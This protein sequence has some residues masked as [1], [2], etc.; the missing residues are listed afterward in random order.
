MKQL[1]SKMGWEIV[2]EEWPDFKGQIFKNRP[3]NVVEM[4]ENTVA[5]YPD[6]LGFIGGDWRLTF[7]E[8]DRIVNRVTAG[9]E[10]HGVK[11]GDHVA[12]LLGVQMEFPL[13]FFALM[14][15][16]AVVVPLNTRFKGMELAY[17][18]ND[19]ESQVLIVDEEYWPSIDSTRGQLKGIEKIF[20]NG[21]HVPR[22]T[23]PFS[24]LK[25][26]K[27]DTFSRA[28]FSESDDAAI[29]Y[30]SGTTGKPKGAILH[31]RGF[32][33]SAMLV[34]DFV[35]FEP[36]D[37][38]MCCIPLFHITGLACVM[39][40]TIFSGVT[41]VY[42]REFK[43]KDF[44]EI[45]AKEKVTQYMG[46]INVVWLMVN[47]PDF[48]QYDF[49]SFKAA[50]LGGSP[51]TE[52][53]VR[54]IFNKLPHLQISVGYG[55]TEHFAIATSTP[56]EDALRKIK[57]VGQC[58]PT[59]DVK[60]V[61][62]EGKEVETGA[63]GEIVLKS[64]KVFKG[65]W[66]NLKAT[67]ET[68]VDGWLHTGDIGKIDE[69][70]FIYILDRKKDMINRGGE[71]IYSLE[72]ENVLGDNPKVLE[73][74]VVGVPDAMMGEVVKACIVL[75][76]GENATQEEIKEFCTERLANYK[77]PKF[78]EFMDCLPRNPAGKVNKPALRYIPNKR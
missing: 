52:E 59:V 72:V 70:G 35:Q 58:H 30:T 31:Q 16:G 9:L 76:S 17:E 77:V 24:L 45:M 67:R 14:K 61:D 5:T 34:S 19:S 41:C 32:V 65:Y 53:M 15:L 18:I 55:L 68:I 33:L 26:N 47:H 50:L 71:K 1:G 57:A 51:A 8:F 22:G 44:L 28:T 64:A 49:S 10:K 73:V 36:G 62:E 13:S 11:K 66:K 7:K 4:L 20:F 54:G 78:V 21:S 42:M 40:S 48:D 37:K 6:K 43:T 56:Y 75:R 2:E 12:L 27:E 29:M 46:V 60:I 38:M 69:E 3:K 74:A 63:I 25:K 39:L 23:L